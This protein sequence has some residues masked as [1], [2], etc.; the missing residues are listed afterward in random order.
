MS[1][2]K[3][4]KLYLYNRY[5]ADA[6]LD[7][8]AKGLLYFYANVYNWKNNKASYWSQRSICASVG[9]SQ[10]TYQKKRKYLEELGWIKVHYRGR[11][12]PCL[13]HVT[14]GFDDPEYD[15][16]SWAQGHRRVFMESE[17]AAILSSASKNSPSTAV[18]QSGRGDDFKQ[19]ASYTVTTNITTE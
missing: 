18:D 9:I 4:D 8:I 15:K 19:Y 12:T 3:Q 7:G 10:N 1:Q 6:K 2:F 11:N 17:L 13:V 14:I 5:I 16:R